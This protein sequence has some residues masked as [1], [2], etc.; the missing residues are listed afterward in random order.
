M[1]PQDGFPFLDLTKFADS[2]A[3]NVEPGLAAFMGDSQAPWGLD[4]LNGAVSNASWKN[5]P[6]W[7]L[8]ATDDKI[9]PP[10]ALRS[11]AKRAG[12]TVAEAKGSHAI[13]VSQPELVGRQVFVL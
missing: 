13:Y 1:P 12:A 6:S 4:A 7:Y 5:K 11:M 10:D 9:I 2:F 3:T 8:V